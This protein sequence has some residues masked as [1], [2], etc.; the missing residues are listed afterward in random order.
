MRALSL[1]VVAGSLAGAALAVVV[2]ETKMPLAWWLLLPL[3]VWII[4]STDHLL[5]ARRIGPSATTF[6]HRFHYR[7]F[8]VLG[9]VTFL[10]AVLAAH[11]IFFELTR[12]PRIFFAGL[13]LGTLV[14]AHLGL[15]QVTRWRGYPAELLIAALYTI[16]IWFGPLL[17]RDQG[18]TGTAVPAIL[19]G[20]FLAAFGNLLVFSLFERHIDA[21]EAPNTIVL[22]GGPVFAERLVRFCAFGA[23]LGYVAIGLS[24]NDDLARAAALIVAMTAMIPAVVYAGRSFFGEHERYRIVCDG[25]FLLYALPYVWQELANS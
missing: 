7:H 3:I 22:A 8:R 5:D 18:I 1:D 21:R 19:L 9:L 11:L 24:Q 13:F 14:L 12:Y 16:G 10:A 6:R 25:V 15:A 2:C 17:Q 20:F 23:V 4:Y